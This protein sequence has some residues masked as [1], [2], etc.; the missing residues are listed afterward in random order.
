MVFTH[1]I[2]K[3]KFMTNIL[4]VDIETIPYDQRVNG[5]QPDVYKDDV[6][7]VC[8]SFKGKNEVQDVLNKGKKPKPLSEDFINRYQDKET[9]VLN[10]NALFDA[11]YLYHH[12]GIK[13]GRLWDTQAIERLLTMGKNAKV[14]LDI[15]LKR[16]FGLELDKSVRDNICLGRLSKKD[17][18][19]VVDDTRYLEL[20]QKEQ[21]REVKELGMERAAYLENNLS[22][23][24]GQMEY[25]G[26]DFDMKLWQ[27]YEKTLINVRNK[28]HKDILDKLDAS[29]SLTFSGEPID[30]INMTSHKDAKEILKS[31][32]IHIKNYQKSTILNYILTGDDEEKVSLMRD[33]Y[34]F[35]KWET[36]LR[37]NY[38]ENV[39]KTT[40]KIHGRTIS[41]GVE[42]KQSTSTG[43]FSS[44]K[45]N[46]QNISKDMDND[47]YLQKTGVNMR[48]LFHAP[49]GWLWI[50]SDYSQIELRIGAEV[51]NERW[52][53]DDFIND[54]CPHC[55]A[56][57]NVL[58]KVVKKGDKERDYGKVCNFGVALYG[59]GGGALI[60]YALMYGMV[61]PLV[62]ANE[63][64]QNVKR[65]N[66]NIE[67][68]G[69]EILKKAKDQRYLQHSAGYIRWFLDDNDLR[70]TVARNTPIQGTAGAI[71][72]E[73]T[74]A[75]YLWLVEN[76]L[77][78]DVKILNIVHDEL[79]CIAKEEIAPYVKEN[80]ERIMVEAGCL[81]MKVV[82]CEVE[83]SMGRTWAEAK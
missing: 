55:T 38:G 58:G 83:G 41:I 27:K 59:G 62:R 74:V 47:K 71:M 14:A 64:A 72:K 25:T 30:C 79:N 69:K 3:G 34:Q 37:F 42:K 82:P 5:G 36:A 21:E 18:K 75:F 61:I 77:E 50:A 40:C 53:I 39:N 54:V 80:L 65:T 33:V 44:D 63:I 23:I 12:Y 22:W 31:N 73:A 32:G 2:S 70:E 68:W 67:K 45:P 26:I 43:R 19:Y 1:I 78:N 24:C 66:V 7:L 48:K 17:I 16:R 6:Y 46:L 11:K 51:T 15:V 13:P 35:K 81:Y 20:L 76:K 52:L 4:A 29:Y 56:A 28:Y 57:G 9:L 49:K 60:N 8:S 10:H